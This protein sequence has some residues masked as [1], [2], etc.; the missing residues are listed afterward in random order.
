MCLVVSSLNLKVTLFS[1]RQYRQQINVYSPAST[2]DFTLLSS[3]SS[4]WIA[5]KGCVERHLAQRYND[6]S[7]AIKSVDHQIGFDTLCGKYRYL[8]QISQ[9]IIVSQSFK[10]GQNWLTNGLTSQSHT[11]SIANITKKDRDINTV[12]ASL[13]ISSS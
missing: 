5:A 12:S 11:T 8:N 13:F 10:S 9:Q 1:C 6:Q 7:R 3:S 2:G 4:S